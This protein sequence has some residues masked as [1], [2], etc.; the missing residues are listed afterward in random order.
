MELGIFEDYAVRMVLYL[1]RNLGRIVSRSEISEAMQIPL[2]V[3]AKIGQ[4]LERAGVL[5]IFRGKKGG[6]RLKKDPQKITLL[7]VVESMRGKITLNKCVDNPNFCAR[8]RVCSVHFIWQELNEKFRE[9]LKI[10]FKRLIE[11]EDK[12]LSTK[13]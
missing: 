1:S 8:E 4:D 10:D 9:M 12:L 5:E 3:L 13:K 2:T 6:Y 11:L 7:E